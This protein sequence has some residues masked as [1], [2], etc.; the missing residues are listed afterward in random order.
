[1]MVR[2]QISLPEDEL[3]QAKAYAVVHGISLAELVRR[4]LRR[5]L[6][7]DTQ[8]SDLSSLI[9]MLDGGRARDSEQVDEIVGQALED[10]YQRWQRDWPDDP[11]P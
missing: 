7:G 8:K 2:T 5:E 6:A 10:E 9:G 3:R 1:M 11:G 4:A